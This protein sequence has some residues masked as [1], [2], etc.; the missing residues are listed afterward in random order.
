MGY[1]EVIIAVGKK[2]KTEV[3]IVDELTVGFD[4]KQI[5]E[6]RTLIIELI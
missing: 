6:F 2:K 5:I 3:I 4:P 1:P